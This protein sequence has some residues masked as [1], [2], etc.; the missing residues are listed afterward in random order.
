MRQSKFH[1]RYESEGRACEHPACEE[2][3]EFRAPGGRRSSFDGPGEYR[4]MCLE[5]VREFNAGYDWF[6]GM[7]ADEI[8][9]AQAP[10]AGWRTDSPAFNPT[11]GVDGMPRWADFADPLDAIGERAHAMRRRAAGVKQEA[12]ARFTP[13]EREAL[14]LMGLGPDADRAGVRRR[15]SDLVRRYHPDRNG[16][17]RSHEAKLQRVVEAYQLLRRAEAL[18]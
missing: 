17:D 6:E 9:A 16:G 13:M 3:G 5:H 2:P 7:S 4:W 12:F 8:Y 15:Y 1:G 18:A 14:T 10:G 11:A